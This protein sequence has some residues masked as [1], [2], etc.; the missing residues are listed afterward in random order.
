MSIVNL[1]LP[2]SVVTATKPG[3]V[4]ACTAVADNVALSPGFYKIAAMGQ[5]LLWKLADAAVVTEGSYLAPGDQEII[6]VPGDPGGPTVNLDFISSL[7]ASADGEINIVEV[8]FYA[9]TATKPNGNI[10]IPA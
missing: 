8:E 5:P 4:V 7:E 9:V 2:F 1:S 3:A 6:K 10:P